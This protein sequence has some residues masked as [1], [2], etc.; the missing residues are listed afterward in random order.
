MAR[1]DLGWK[2][3]LCLIATLALQRMSLWLL[4][5][6]HVLHSASSPQKR[7]G[8]SSDKVGPE[9][10]PPEAGSSLSVW[11]P[12]IPLPFQTP[13]PYLPQLLGE[14]KWSGE[15][16]ARFPLPL[17]AGPPGSSKRGS[18]K[19]QHAQQRAFLQVKSSSSQSHVKPYSTSVFSPLRPSPQAPAPCAEQTLVHALRG[20][21]QREATGQAGLAGHYAA[22]SSE[23]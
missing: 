22:P 8:P 16:V 2:A 1:S 23:Q 6:S 21:G 12:D 13:P 4:C 15:C 7:C 19:K 18:R 14:I 3:P 11:G 9:Q 17:S 10:T 5:I 20:S